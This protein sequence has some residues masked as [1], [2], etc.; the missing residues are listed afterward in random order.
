MRK[1]SESDSSRKIAVDT[2]ELQSMLSCGR[3]TAVRI[4][5]EAQAR[6]QFGKRVLWNVNKVQSFLDRTSE[7]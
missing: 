2:K 3:D 6:L 1:T 7:P 5:T 4:G